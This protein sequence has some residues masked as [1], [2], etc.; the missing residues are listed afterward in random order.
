MIR[1]AILF[2]AFLLLW[3]SCAPLWAHHSFAA[4]YDANKPVKLT[5]A[6]TKI[7]L[8]NPHSWIYID[9]K[10]ENGKTVNW[11][12]EMAAPDSL[13]RRGFRSAVKVGMQVTIE[14]FLA[15]DGTPAANGQKIHL[16]D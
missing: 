8:T 13:I 2:C 9:V 4:E 16:P 7:E 5:G 6:V 1:S 12:F 11:K 3:L 10:D 15:K 14:G